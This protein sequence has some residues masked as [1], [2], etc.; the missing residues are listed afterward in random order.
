MV[1]NDTVSRR[2][3]LGRL[4]GVVVGGL[5]LESSSRRVAG[6]QQVYRVQAKGMYVWEAVPEMVRS[7]ESQGGLL[8]RCRRLGLDELYVAFPT[9]LAES[10][11]SSLAEMVRNIA[12]S[13]MKTH[14]VLSP[15]GRNASSLPSLVRAVRDWASTA[16]QGI[17][18]HINSEPGGMETVPFLDLL[19]RQL[20]RL[21]PG[22]HDLSLAIR[23]GWGAEH[24]RK[25]N[26]VRD[27]GIVDWVNVMAYRDTAQGVRN[28][29]KMAMRRRK[30]GNDWQ[31]SS[32]PLRN[33]LELQKT[34]YDKVNFHR[35]GLT[36]AGEVSRKLRRQHPFESQFRGIVLHD[37]R[38]LLQLELQRA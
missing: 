34:T 5:G 19:G 29:T 9:D 8:R 23:F 18:I 25:A 36:Q 32:K 37:Y 2:N 4:S 28:T 15:N 3:V 17:G 38:A 31:Y 7:S 22:R 21:N 12:E 6:I 26:R 30:S 13:G 11:P 33:V 24:P 10:D 14:F 16:G 27:H 1:V 35:E 20:D